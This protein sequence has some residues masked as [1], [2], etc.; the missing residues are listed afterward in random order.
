MLLRDQR[1]DG[2]QHRSEVVAQVT[3]QAT[4]QFVEDS[5]TLADT[6]IAVNGFGERVFG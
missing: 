6:N 2:L 1:Q 3:L 4:G 5:R